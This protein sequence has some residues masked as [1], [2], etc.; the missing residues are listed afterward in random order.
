MAFVSP[1]PVLPSRSPCSLHRTRRYSV[2]HLPQ[3]SMVAA[4]ER[5]TSKTAKDASDLIGNT[6]LVHLN[7]IPK[8]EGCVAEIYCKMES[9]NPLSSVK[10]RIGRSM[11]AGAEKDGKIIPGKTVLIEPTSGNTGIALAF[12]AATKGYKLIL[13]MPDSMS[14]ERRMVLRAFNAEVVLTPSAKG[15]KGAVNKAEEILNQLPDGYMLQQ[16]A[17]PHNP[18][19]HYETTGPEIHNAIQCD[20]FVSGV[21]TGGTVT[22]AGKY[23]KEN[24]PNV[25]IVAVEPS[26]SP[27]L[28]GG[29]PSAHKIQG[30][31]AGFV[32]SVLD[33]S[34][35]DE[36]VQVPSGAA[37]E[38]A[39][40]LAVEE[41]LFCGISSGAA[42]IAAT[43]VGQRPEMKGKNIVTIIPSFGER[44]LT[45]ALFDK[46]RE[47]AYNLKYEYEGDK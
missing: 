42:V 29:K 28:S 40:R 38:M 25:Y 3:P 34:I 23:L 31:G 36:V 1:L 15:M 19:A 9:L 21:G 14:I 22:G 37:I 35:Y 30:I 46:Q 10:D 39:R 32:P 24:N 5:S 17:N 47:E 43:T 8:A 44:Y 27:V 45:S 11:I 26:E 18:K 20:V 7:K 6:P 13:V 41:G 33:T 12:I 16:F 2:P 4:P